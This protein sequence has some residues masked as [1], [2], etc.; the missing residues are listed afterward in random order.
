MIGLPTDEKMKRD[1]KI[2]HSTNPQELCN[3]VHEHIGRGWY[4]IGGVSVVLYDSDQ[5]QFFQAL[6]KYY[7]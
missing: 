1:Y 4:P 7:I 2:V 5:F 6:E 3:K